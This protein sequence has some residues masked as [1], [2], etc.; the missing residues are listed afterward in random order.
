ML[1]VLSGGPVVPRPRT[2]QKRAGHLCS[3]SA[4]RCGGRRRYGP[5]AAARTSGEAPA[6][7]LVR[8]V[9]AGKCRSRTGARGVTGQRPVIHRTGQRPA[10]QGDGQ[11][12]GATFAAVAVR[13]AASVAH[14]A[15]LF[16][17]K[18]GSRA[19]ICR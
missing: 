18:F 15:R 5:V 14:L 10:P 19:S 3:T 8:L 12:A 7:T 1:R 4:I 11:G 6:A 9:G 2:T 16:P 13:R 17:V